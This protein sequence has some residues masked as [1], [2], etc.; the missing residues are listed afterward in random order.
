MNYSNKQILTAAPNTGTVESAAVDARFVIGATVQ[1]WFSD[2]T[3]AGTLKLQ[4][5]ND[6]KSPTHWNDI[7]NATV[8]VAAGATSM[9]PILSANFCYQWIRVAFV[10][11]G[12]SGTMTAV[13]HTVGA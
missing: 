10:S 4:A 8:A 1:A 13:I 9:T 3:A 5:S 11:S 12:G 6:V 7:P 2:V